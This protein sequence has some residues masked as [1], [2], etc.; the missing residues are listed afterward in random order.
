[1]KCYRNMKTDEIVYKEEAENYALD[2][3]GIIVI[4]KGTN[5]TFTS[6]Q[7][8]NIQ[9]TVDWYFSGNWYEEEIKE[10]EEPSIF[11]L[12]NE[13]CELEDAEY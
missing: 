9:E 10:V 5:G 3:L 11:E 7:I 2:R 1:M 13:E 12:I 4:P 8:E 6:E